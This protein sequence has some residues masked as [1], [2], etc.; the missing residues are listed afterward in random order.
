MRACKPRP[1]PLKVEGVSTLI[2]WAAKIRIS[3]PTL[4]HPHVAPNVT[5]VQHPAACIPYTFLTLSQRKF[6]RSAQ[7]AATSCECGGISNHKTRIQLM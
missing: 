6:L 7:I 3:Y 1:G 5:L 4:Q 2:S